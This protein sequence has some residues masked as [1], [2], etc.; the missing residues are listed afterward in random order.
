MRVAEAARFDL[1][2]RELGR[3][4]TQLAQVSERLATGRRINRLIIVFLA[5]A[6]VMW[7]LDSLLTAP[8]T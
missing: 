2:R 4:S 3:T 5:L 8:G 6:L 7:V 1:L